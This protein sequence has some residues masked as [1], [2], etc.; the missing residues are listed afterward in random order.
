MLTV[1]CFTI[2]TFSNRKQLNRFRKL[3][4]RHQLGA[5]CEAVAVI[6]A[7]ALGEG[8]GISPIIRDFL[9]NN[10]ELEHILGC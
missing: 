9:A 4:S 2:R 1:E 7:H 5:G 6:L 3:A 8:S 10:K